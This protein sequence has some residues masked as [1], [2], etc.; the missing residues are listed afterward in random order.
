MRSIHP[1]IRRPALRRAGLV[2]LG[3]LV[4]G[5]AHA[6]VLG[7]APAPEQVTLRNPDGSTRSFDPGVTLN[8]LK[9]KAVGPMERHRRHFSTDAQMEDGQRVHV[10]FDM[11]G[12]IA[13][14]ERAEFEPSRTAPP[15]ADPQPILAKVQEAGFGNPVMSEL[16][17]GHA[18][19]RA[20]NQKNE[21]VELHVD[22]AGTI[23]RQIWVRPPTDEQMRANEQ[24]RPNGPIR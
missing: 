12:R 18:V 16:K 1:P 3:L 17:R 11:L 7:P 6:Q 4:S 21:P 9:L 2:A 20:T 13:E 14:I 22:N 19:V 15:I 8:E 23:Y 5:G 10:T 24:M